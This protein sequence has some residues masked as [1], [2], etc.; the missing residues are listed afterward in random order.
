MPK[1]TTFLTYDSQAEEAAKLYTSVFKNS[2]ITGTSRYGEGAPVPSGTVMTVSFELDGTPFVALNGGPS[3]SF[4]E[5]FS[6]YVDCDDQK[7]VDH[8]WEKLSA[9]GEPGR[10]GWLKDRFGVSWQ[11]IPRA[12]PE[13]MGDRDPRRAK[14]V[15]DA[16][17]K[18]GKIDIAGLKR[19]YDQK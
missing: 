1:I 17:L 5:G 10:C 12:L 3:F 16:M 18:M 15:M 9:G 19:A 6:L 8:Y 7:E 14:R 13:M 11:I 4:A 2:R